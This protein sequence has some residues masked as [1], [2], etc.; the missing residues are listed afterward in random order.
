ME[1]AT[2]HADGQILDEDYEYGSFIQSKMYHKGIRCTDCHDPHTARQARGQRGLHVV[3]PASGGQVRQPAHHF[4]Q[5]GIRSARVRRV[6][7]AE[8]TY[9]EVDPRR[10][11]S[12]RNPRPDLSVALGS[13][14]RLY[15]GLSRR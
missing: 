5:P 6:P 8:T 3:P 9:M 10:D 2:Y 1:R 4:H 11:H 12:I 13:A 7:H 14:Q 15:A